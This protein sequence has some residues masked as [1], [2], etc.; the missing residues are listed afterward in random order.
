M[1]IKSIQ[2]EYEF[3]KKKVIRQPGIFKDNSFVPTYSFDM[4]KEAGILAIISL[5]LT[6]VNTMC[7]LVTAVLVLKVTILTCFLS[8]FIM[9]YT[10]L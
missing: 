7:I 8:Y 4:R 9:Y 5:V 3:L 6:I 10:N 1:S 2:L